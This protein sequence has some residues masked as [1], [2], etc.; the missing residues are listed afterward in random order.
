[1]YNP[2]A[3]ET[4]YS[5][6]MPDNSQ[7]MDGRPFLNPTLSPAWQSLS[8][9]ADYYAQAFDLREAF[10]QD[11]QRFERLSLRAPYMLVDASKNLWDDRVFSTLLDLAAHM[12]FVQQRAKLLQGNIVNH[13]EQQ[14]AV[15]AL[16][17]Q[18]YSSGNYTAYPA[19][20]KHCQD[21]DAMLALADAIR[22]DADIHDVVHIG[23]GGSSLGPELALQALR[24]YKT[25]R[26]RLHIVSNLDGH[27]L[28]ETLQQCV[29]GH[30]LFIAA[31]KSWSTA[32]T[33]QNLHSCLAWLAAAGYRADE[34][35]VAVT[36]KPQAPLAMG[37]QS[38]LRMPADIG[39]RYSLWSAVG[40]PLAV[41]IG[42]EG[43]RQ[44]LLGA[45]TMDSHFAQAP[46]TENAPLWLGLLDVWYSSFL[47]MRS[48]CVTPYHHGLR[49]LPAYLQQLEMESNGKGVRQCGTLTS[50][51]TALAVWGEAGTNGQHAYFQWLHQGTHRI[52]VEFITVCQADHT[53]PLHQSA[54][55][56][57]ALAQAQALMQGSKASEGQL[58]GHQDFV[59]NR[60]STF[61][62]L[63][64]QL[65]PAS[66]GALIA[67]HEHRV[68]VSGLLWGI[69]SFDQWGVEL[70]K[71]LAKDI[72]QR[73]QV[74]NISDLDA[75]TQGL[76]RTILA[77]TKS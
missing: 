68:F 8:T 20:E 35:V 12:G 24:P 63:L 3:I 74:G 56:A 46:L 34:R 60:P 7:Q 66:F 37:I 49:R 23:I 51:P 40:L 29:P 9:I 73:M 43:F 72:Q 11:E 47:Q 10:A 27:D 59:G 39:G 14:A 5:S 48:K 54:L 69:N 4:G 62:M 42:P 32:E 30:T 52:P 75:S 16:L 13:T 18:A 58:S 28:T 45:S 44:M 19:M 61:I 21:L 38:V 2:V 53:L 77:N 25:T 70:G 26:Q 64:E 36:A 15:H 33:L 31:S 55:L 22:A 41:A 6:S 67:L 50:Y 71:H 76:L 57:N 17:R 1:M 65:S